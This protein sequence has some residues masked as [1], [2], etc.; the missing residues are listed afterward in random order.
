MF[1]GEF[2]YSRYYWK[3][4]PENRMFRSINLPRSRQ[5]SAVLTTRSGWVAA[6]W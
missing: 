4:L 5:D 6:K 3:L 2:D 1:F